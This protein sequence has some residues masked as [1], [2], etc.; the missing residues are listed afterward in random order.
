MGVKKSTMSDKVSESDRNES[1]A[2]YQNLVQITKK[3]PASR[4]GRPVHVA[5]VTRWILEGARLRDG[6]RLRLRATRLPGRWVVEKVAVDEFLAALTAD[7]SGTP[8]SSSTNPSSSYKMRPVSD[9]HKS[10]AAAAKELDK[11]GIR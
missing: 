3:L 6:T 4:G 10:A 5:T 8:R 1:I 11:I 2:I 9:L 7:R